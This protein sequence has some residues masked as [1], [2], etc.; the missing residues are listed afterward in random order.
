[1]T[2]D[3]GGSWSLASFAGADQLIHQA[4]GARAHIS[5]P[6][7]MHG[8]IL[9]TQAGSSA[10][11]FGHLFATADGGKTWSPLPYPPV[12]GR[13]QFVSESTGW[14]TGGVHQNLLY[15][16]QDGG[17][18]WLE[19]TI[20]LPEDVTPYSILG[21]DGTVYV[22]RPRVEGPYF[23]TPD[24]GAVTLLVRVTEL[25]WDLL[26]Y[27]T[28]D[29]GD[30]W[31]LTGRR[32]NL[33]SI[34]PLAFFDSTSL[35]VTRS[36]NTF[37]FRHNS[38]LRSA[39]IPAVLKERGTDGV[40]RADFIDAQHGWL[41][42]SDG[43]L[44]GTANGGHS[45]T[46]L[47][48][49]PQQQLPNPIR[50]PGKAEIEP[51]AAQGPRPNIGGVEGVSTFGI[52]SCG[53]I[54]PTYINSLYGPY[55]QEVA[56]GNYNQVYGFYLGGVTTVPAGCTPVNSTFINQTACAGWSYLPIW[57]G[58]QAPC[59]PGSQPI[60]STPATAAAEGTGDADST[61]LQ[62]GN[63]GLSGSTAYLD[64][65][66]Y[67]T[68]AGSSCSQAVR[69][70]VNAW[71]GEMHEYGYYAGVYG[72][73]SDINQDMGP[74]AVDNVP[75]NIWVAN[76]SVG[77]VTNPLPGVNNGWWIEN[78]RAH[79]YQGGTALIKNQSYQWDLDVVSSTVAVMI[80]PPPSCDEG[81]NAACI[82]K[83]SQT[84]G[85]TCMNCY[86][87]PAGGPGPVCYNNE[88]SCGCPQYCGDVCITNVQCSCPGEQP[89]CE[90]NDGGMLWECNN[91]CTPIVL[92]PFGK[93]F[94]LTNLSQG[95]KFRVMPDSPLLQMSWP[96]QA[97]QNGWLALDRNGNGLI[98]DFTELFGNL[99]PQPESDSPNGFKALA[100]FDDPSNGRQWER[101]NRRGRRNLRSSPSLDRREP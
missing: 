50:V 80:D 72:A 29:R 9:L 2:T 65:E 20:P 59:G 91:N 27:S 10:S 96:D 75:D 39:P 11:S 81:C 16:T 100:V 77:P 34:G 64:I 41:L 94:H 98:D 48:Q 3:G 22:T 79:Q 61:I 66:A 53:T 15:R 5:F 88:I 32:N 63:I 95:V 99:T 14:L 6:D 62:L 68:T 30:T 74:G 37:D 101:R 18:T 92:H 33:D 52:D 73:G 23:E 84:C 67:T 51:H 40:L 24:T 17:Q 1:M 83:S 82:N 78:Q 12:D 8:W 13:I 56:P 35:E 55:G 46:I 44:L 25:T 26:T 43:S 89:V 71:V 38:A 19:V 87:C 28:A 69:T 31:Q 54:P 7:A 60:S 42:S 21:G 58:Y 97:G 85:G 4:Y 70:Y 49:T 57:D 86:Q 76:Y 45:V 93:G 90:D 47:M 36:N